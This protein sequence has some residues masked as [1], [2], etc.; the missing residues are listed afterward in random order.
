MQS[1]FNK[2]FSRW[3]EIL[4]H[5]PGKIMLVSLVCIIGLSKL[6]EIISFLGFGITL[7]K[8]FEDEQ[9][10]WSPAN[11][12]SLKD[13]ALKERLFTEEAAFEGLIFESKKGG[14]VLT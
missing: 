1:F 7:Q 12:R 5:H 3:G 9:V 11:S 8:P 10:A 6:T 4:A 13:K 14:N 2:V